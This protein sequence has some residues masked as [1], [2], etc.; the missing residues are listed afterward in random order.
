MAIISDAK[1]GFGY[2]TDNTGNSIGNAFQLSVSAGQVSGSGVLASTSDQDFWS[3][4]TGAGQITLNVNVATGVNNLVAKLVLE[5][6][7]GNVV[8]TADDNSGY[9]ATLTANVGAGT[10]YVVAESHGGYGDVGQYSISGTVIPTSTNPP[11]A[12][13]NLTASAGDT[14]ATLSWNTSSGATSYNIYR[15]LTAGGEG[16]TAYKTGVTTTSYTDTG[17]TDGTTYYYKVTAVSSAGESGQSN[18]A[19]AT[20]QLAK[21][22]IPTGLKAS[23]GD[24]Q[25]SLTWNASSGA[26]TYN[27]YRSLTPGG[28]GTVA[29]KTGITATSFTDTGLTNGTTYYYKVTAVNA[30]GESGQSNE[31]SVTPQKATFSLRIDSGGGAS[32]NFVS[33]ADYTGGHTFSTQHTIDTS[34]V[35]NPA[36]QSVYQ[37]ER[38]GNFTYTI[39]N[40]T[41]GATYTVR[42]H[43]AEIYWGAAGKRLFNVKINGSQVLSNFDIFATAG[44]KYKA[45][46]EQFT[47]TADANGNL[48]I[49]YVSVR[50]NA[51]SSGIEILSS[52]GA[53]GATTNPRIA[54]F[55]ND[56]ERIAQ[57]F[58]N[59]PGYSG[60]TNWATHLS[61]DTQA[62]Q[63]YLTQWANKTMTQRTLDTLLGQHVS[64][65]QSHS[66]WAD[67]LVVQLQL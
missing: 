54:K 55:G 29:F 5:D 21:P 49:Q 36:P 42:L 44:A 23:A 48:T 32:G 60:W 45:I 30:A 20:P 16:A 15:S 61:H 4:S 2:R 22:A 63:T 27:V 64:H 66:D 28:E 53:P 6:A 56:L 7:N 14:Q 47:A 17:L 35:T 3:F 34:A 33:D 11:T 40:L 25:V 50:D 38:Y 52:S 57:F 13:T 43:F 31:A 37:S 51:K 62:L 39:P 67:D 41:P 9:N 24:G 12:P 19:S 10:Y 59:T 58:S 1:N 46:V 65:T 18:E 8:G 26:A